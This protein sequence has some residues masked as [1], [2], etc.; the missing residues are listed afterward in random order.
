MNLLRA[1]LPLVPILA[2]VIGACVIGLVSSPAV[3]R[4]RRW[5]YLSA[6]VITWLS[7]VGLGL[8]QADTARFPFGRLFS[9]YGQVLEFSFGALSLHVA[10]L[11]VGVLT[12]VRV[13]GLNR[14]QRRDEAVFMLVLCSL[15]IAACSADNLLTLCAVWSVLD[16]VLIVTSLRETPEQELHHAV[17]CMM[18]HLVATTV[19]IMA[20]VLVAADYNQTNFAYF[21]MDRRPTQLLM[22]A[23]ILRMGAFPLPMQSRYRWEQTLVALCTGGYLWLQTAALSSHMVGT[24]WLSALSV[25]ALLATAAMAL[26]ARDL[27]A[28]L[29]YLSLHSITLLILGPLLDSDLGF[30][31]GLM[32]LINLGMT[33]GALAVNEQVRPFPPVGPRAR[34]PLLVA[35]AALGGWP[36]TAGF[37][38]RWTLF[39]AAWVAGAGSIFLWMSVTAVLTSVPVWRQFHLIRRDMGFEEQARPQPILWAALSAAAALA[40][41]LVVLAVYPPLL[42]RIWPAATMRVSLPTLFSLPGAQ[43][44]LVLLLL[45]AV[46]GPLLGGHALDRA[47]PLSTRRSE[48]TEMLVT[49]VTTLRLDWLYA[50]IESG[51]SVIKRVGER[52]ISVVEESLYPSWILLWSIIIVMYFLER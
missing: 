30:A 33:L 7:L 50:G 43:P 46:A 38:A 27:P 25:G 40:L 8:I 52:V 6:L 4:A 14:P 15:V 31:G 21:L 44:Q 18:M 37:M 32:M 28:A 22:L 17:R 34:W 48:A 26:A 42:A 36:L 23:A 1:V 2:P 29:P 47:M 20:T 5:I 3:T 11:F 49:I 51:L 12:L 16:F 13:A 19:L 10:M 35:L 24:G 41:S 45:S 39:N 9:V